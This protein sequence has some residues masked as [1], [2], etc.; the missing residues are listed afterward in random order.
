M[1][2][3]DS[4]QEPSGYGPDELPLLHPAIIWKY[5]MFV[6]RRAR[7]QRYCYTI[8]MKLHVYLR[9]AGL[10]SRRKAEQLIAEG[11]VVVNGDVAHI[12]QQID[13][14]ESIYADG[15]LVKAPST[16]KKFSYVVLNKPVGYTSTTAAFHPGE[17]NVLQLLPLELKTKTQWQIVGRLDKDS[18]GL[19]LLTDDGHSGYVLTHPKYQIAKE[20][21]VTVEKEVPKTDLEKLV[22]GVNSEEGEVYQFQNIRKIDILT[23][24]CQLTEGKKRE[25]REA[26]RLLGNRVTTLKRVKIGPIELGDLELGASRELNTGEIENLTSF[27]ASKAPESQILEEQPTLP[28]DL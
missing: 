13:G 4:N 5:I 18:E 28:E 17:K 1:R 12:G 10:A 26:F 19:V 25:I 6:L 23:Y 22:K 20:Y 8:R 11:R 16:D 3:L 9:N 24:V 15:V 21:L 27:I 2:D 7:I 14:T